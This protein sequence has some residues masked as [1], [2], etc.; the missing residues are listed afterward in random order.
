MTNLLLLILSLPI[1]FYSFSG[2]QA[3]KAGLTV[4][5]WFTEQPD[6]R[7][8][9]ELMK[10]GIIYLQKDAIQ[11]ALDLGASPEH[12]LI[13]GVCI[14]NQEYI[15]WGLRVGATLENLL[16]WGC[17]AK[18]LK[19]VL[20]A[21]D[22]GVSVNMRDERDLTPLM[23]AFDIHDMFLPT[24]HRC[25]G[26]RAEYIEK[27]NKFLREQVLIIATLL[28][29][30]ADIRLKDRDGFDVFAYMFHSTPGGR[31]LPVNLV[32][33]SY[34]LAYLHIGMTPEQ[35]RYEIANNEGFPSRY[36][37]TEMPPLIYLP[38]DRIYGDPE[39]IALREDFLRRYP[40]YLARI[41]RN[42]LQYLSPY[43]PH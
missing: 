43:I 42:A 29:R 21:L 32:A 4:M 37:I 27:H 26:N 10:W 9:E 19:A 14:D 15:D 24:L 18:M 3:S 31:E 34:L 23:Y 28:Q 38:Y 39:I 11:K 6:G 25:R 5:S 33:S 41:E 35:S 17:Q 7:N 1:C 36:G 8:P 22:H 20:Y 30:G 13:R 16:L 40:D 12:I 2:S